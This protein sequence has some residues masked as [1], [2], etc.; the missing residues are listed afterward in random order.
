MFKD[1]LRCNVWNQIRQHDLRAFG[2][3]LTPE[4]FGEAGQRAGL[5]IGRSALHLGNLVWLALGSAL[6]TMRS[7]SDILGLTLKLLED[8]PAWSS[9]DLAA[10]RKRSRRK[11]PRGS[12]HRPTGKDPTR[13]SEEAF[14]KARQRMP[15]CFWVA[16][17]VVLGERFQAQHGERVC[18]KGFRLLAL[19]GTCLNLP[20]QEPLKAHFG[21]SRN[22]RG[23]GRVQARMVMLQFP[24]VRLPWR[25]E[26]CPLSEGERTIAARLLGEL[27]RRDLVLMDRGFWSYGLFCQLQQQGACFAIR[28]FGGVRF[29][30]LRRLG[31]K[32][33]L[34]RWNKPTGPRWRHSPW[35]PSITLRVIQYQIKGFR[36]TA[37]V[38][39]VTDPKRISH[40]EWVHLTTDTE[41]GRYV[42]QGLYHRRWEIE[43]TFCELKVRQGLEGHLRG[44]TPAAIRYEV[45]GHVLLYLLVRWLMVEA[46]A[47]QNLDPLRLSFT[48]ALR[49][50]TDLQP[51]LITSSP[52]RVAQVLLPRLL[53]RIASHRVAYRP[54][55][56]YPRP[57][58]TKTRVDGRG[59]RYLPSKLLRNAA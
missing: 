14:V 44:R 4:T 43:T 5:R 47:Q 2:K 3:L 28:Q 19:D 24:L 11:R 17:I 22:G 6:H 42:H 50:L 37:V 49:E 31:P 12:P 41:A 29:Q 58:D 20:R 9:T 13:V 38:S 54:G 52:Q 59:K 56:H 35:P 8:S 34:V 26:L 40:A 1:E 55:R 36:P 16:L 25:Y 21:T 15:W 46:A 57:Y 45:A 7:F 51:A 30:T 18:W 39:N 32:D 48:G 10:A 27:G 23:K 53:R 33:R